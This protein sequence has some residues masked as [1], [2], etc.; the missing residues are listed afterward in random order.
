MKLVLTKVI[1]Y[2]CPPIFVHF[3]TKIKRALFPLPYK[4]WKGF[5][6][7]YN[8]FDEMPANKS[9]WTSQAW[10]T[11]RSKR[12]K[13]IIATNALNLFTPDH[14]SN[15]FAIT[16]L[17]LNMALK[18]SERLSVLD[19]A[20]GAGEVYQAVKKGLIDKNAVE[21]HVVDN[22][23]LASIGKRYIDDGDRLY[24]HENLPDKTHEY[25]LV[26]IST[27]LQYIEE[28]Y[29]ILKKLLNYK[30]QFLLLARLDAGEHENLKCVQYVHGT[31]T[32]CQHLNVRELVS[33]LESEGY[34]P[35]FS[36]MDCVYPIDMV[37]KQLHN[38]NLT[39]INCL[40]EKCL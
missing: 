39:A 18:R 5:F 25:D 22:K 24:F 23:E 13:S 19:F 26:H 35:V 12:L 32:P 14:I 27:S 38:E 11:S 17:T 31:P 33:F 37:E 8:S 34:A 7:R 21:W 3:L 1:K 16:L 4:H 6:G 9:V 15:S 40:F 20:G 2:F 36:C 28:P 30:P 10:L 29:E